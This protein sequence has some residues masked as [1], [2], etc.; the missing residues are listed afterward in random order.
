MWM[1][2]NVTQ[3]NW[4]EDDAHKSSI[5]DNAEVHPKVEYSKQA[6][7]RKGQNNDATELCQGDTSKNLRERESERDNMLIQFQLHG[8]TQFANKYSLVISSQDY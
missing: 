2:T 8:R 5:K 4:Q 7:F 6:G 1:L 3:Q